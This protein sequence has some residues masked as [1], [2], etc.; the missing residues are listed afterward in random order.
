MSRSDAAMVER[1]VPAMTFQRI[2]YPVPAADI[3]TLAV[4]SSIIAGAAMDR[5]ERST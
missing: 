3:P 1:T 2:P 5:L 4:K